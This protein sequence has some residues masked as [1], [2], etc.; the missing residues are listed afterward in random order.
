MPLNLRLKLLR[1][2]NP[3]CKGS[4]DAAGLDLHTPYNVKAFSN[5]PPIQLD[6]A[7]SVEGVFEDG[8]LP[9][10]ISSEFSAGYMGLIV[11]RSGL[12]SKEGTHVRNLCGIIDADYRGEWQA[13]LRVDSEQHSASY[14]KNTAVLQVIFL[15]VAEANSY[16]IEL[17]DGTEEIFNALHSAAVRETG[18]FGSTS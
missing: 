17:Q 5:M 3:P 9:L 16:I 8:R 6:D 10:G 7:G 1:D 15:P 18:G 4:M 14:T 12:G 11:S 13:A 2:V